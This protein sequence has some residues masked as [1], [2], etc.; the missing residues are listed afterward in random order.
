METLPPNN[1]VHAHETIVL[2]PS[3]G[4]EKLLS[5]SFL[6][7]LIT[8]FLGAMNDNLFR[9]LVAW[10]GGDLAVKDPVFNWLM[11]LSGS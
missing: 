7:F 9:W 2:P 4:H 10:I 8:Q 5:P 6:G 1:A 3:N 11:S